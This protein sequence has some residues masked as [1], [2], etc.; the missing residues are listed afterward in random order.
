MLDALNLFNSNTTDLI[1][2]ACPEVSNLLDLESLK[3]HQIPQIFKVEQRTVK[4]ILSSKKIDQKTM[5]EIKR[6][7]TLREDPKERLMRL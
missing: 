1:K 6:H 3:K 4:G 2:E 5:N 7:C